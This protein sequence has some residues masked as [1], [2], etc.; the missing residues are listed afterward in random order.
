MRKLA[1][2]TMLLSAGLL[3]SCNKSNP[4]GLSASFREAILQAD[5]AV[6][7]DFREE[8]MTNRAALEEGAAKA[9]QALQRAL[10]Q[11]RNASD[12]NTY[13]ILLNCYSKDHQRYDTM[14]KRKEGGA[15]SNAAAEMMLLG[16]DHDTCMSEFRR[17]TAPDS[18]SVPPGSE[19]SCL[20]EARKTREF[21]ESYHY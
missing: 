4:T 11:V 5:K 10:T 20:L 1:C 9:K 19:N 17:W 2:L 14:L 3:V 7:E 8:N 12:E 15:S 18:A 21:L 6:H 13:L 16:H